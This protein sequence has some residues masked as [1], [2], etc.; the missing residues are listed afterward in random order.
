MWT[1]QMLVQVVFLSNNFQRER[2]L[3]RSTLSYL[4]K[5]SKKCPLFTENY[6]ES[7]QLFRNMNT[8]SWDHHSLFVSS[9]TTNQFFLLWGRKGQLSRRFFRYQVIITK[10][11]NLRIIWRPGLIL[12]F[13]DILS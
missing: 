1:P 5:Q 13:P 9:V 7:Y 10:F 6:A 8:T 3:S 4:T 2:E 12:A 11:Q